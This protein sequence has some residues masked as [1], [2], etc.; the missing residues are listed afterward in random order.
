MEPSVTTELAMAVADLYTSRLPADVVSKARDCVLDSLGCTIGGTR[1]RPVRQVVDSV[2]AWARSGVSTVPGLLGSY[3]APLAA[4]G[5]A[6]LADALDFND[7]VAG[8]G[9]PGA[10]V[11]A[12]ALSLGEA[13]D[14]SGDDFLRAIV[15]GYD[16]AIR[17]A[18]ARSPSRKRAL[19][20]RGQPWAVFGA[21]AAA[22]ALL[23]LDARQ[24]ATAFGL[25]AQHASVPYDGKWYE[26]PMSPLK[27]NYGWAAMGGILAAQL[28]ASGTVATPNVLDGDSG[29]WAMSA[30]DQWNPEAALADL[31]IVHTILDVGFKPYPTCRFTHPALGA[32]ESMLREH[33]VAVEAIRSVTIRTA[34]W[35]QVFADYHPETEIG[36]QYS[37]PY[38]AAMLILGTLTAPDLSDTRVTDLARR[39]RVETDPQID[40]EFAFSTLPAAVEVQLAGGEVLRG[41]LDTPPGSP[42][43]PL[44]DD[45]LADKFARLVEPVLGTSKAL[46]L[47]ARI[48]LDDH[49]PS[50]RGLTLLTRPDQ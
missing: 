19:R 32:L 7:S 9:H 23:R 3:P 24:V 18:R 41:R 38:A 2:L 33:P 17:L 13:R 30:S 26:R 25:A 16:V 40:E 47:R 27:N 6:Q 8:V 44:A 34:R 37:L 35:G 21:T 43:R 48:L 42:E 4:Y 1:C 14:A 22:S 20:V 45:F 28:A 12:V 11:I 36:A 50:P 5:S 29:F 46:D 49:F 31:G 10:S 15:A 39:V